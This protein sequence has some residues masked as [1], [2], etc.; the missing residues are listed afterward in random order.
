MPPVEVNRR[1]FLHGAAAAGLALSQGQVLE[2]AVEPEPRVVKLGIIGLGNRGTTLARTLLELPGTQIVAVCDSELKHSVRATGIIEKAGGRRPDQLDRIDALLARKDIE[3]VAVALPCDLH[4]DVY[5]D[6]LRS[7][8]H[9]YGE[10]PL[11]LSLHECDRVL[12]EAQ[13]QSQLVTR[14]GFQ[15]RWNPRYVEGVALARRGEIGRLL[16]ADSA[17]I[18]SNGPMLGHGGWLGSRERSGDW[19][20]E[21]AAHVWDVVCWLAGGL[22]EQAFGRGRRELFAGNP[23]GRNVTD[24]YSVQLDWANGFSTTFL[25]SW[26][27]PSDD[28]FTGNSLRVIGELGGL[29]LAGGSVTFRDRSRP[30]Q[31][32]HPGNQPDTK[33]ALASFL[34]AVRDGEEASTSMTSLR[35]AR[36]ATKVGLLV[37]MAVDENRVVRINEIV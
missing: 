29:D 37:R 21:Q 7:G 10:K 4:A 35:E 13:N 25:Q 14:V 33:L 36:D 26:I 17:W 19:M 28:A 30:R 15:R 34:K 20:V 2:G 31:P 16:Q 11:A 23:V 6:V 8:K 12:D 32:L 9:L 3:A 18:S 27:A 1:R 5:V 24:H 22:P